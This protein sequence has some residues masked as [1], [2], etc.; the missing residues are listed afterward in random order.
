MKMKCFTIAILPVVILI[1]TILSFAVNT[2]IQAQCETSIIDI[3]PAPVQ[4][5]TI[6][7]IDFDHFES[8]TLLFTVRLGPSAGGDTVRLHI[9]LNINL[10]NGSTY[11]NAA[12]FTSK[13]FF[14]PQAG[15]TYTNLDIGRSIQRQDFT[16]D[17]RAKE[18]VQDVAL[19]TGKF[20]A[21]KYT[22]QIAI[23]CSDNI[24]L[25]GPSIDIVLLNSSR[26]DLLSP[27]EGETT[28]EF[29]LFEFFH[30]GNKAVLT[31][32]EINPDQSREDAISHEPPMVETELLGQNSF[33]YSGGRPLEF[34][35]TYAWKVVSKTAGPGGTEVEVSSPIRLFTVSSSP[36]IRSEDFILTYLKDTYGNRYPKI[37]QDIDKDNYI[38]TG[39]YLLNGSTY[40]KEDLLKLLNEL[41]STSDSIELS[42]E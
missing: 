1:L 22:F 24:P 2:E 13:G 18:D 32:A 31:V 41:R 14:V 15:A 23:I 7:D 27:R 19:A 33:L 37:F 9:V 26:V 17:S 12:D 36:Q 25:N 20:P 35:K 40:S 29:P 3:I 21:G 28:N 4:Q 42:F 8:A 38:L 11:P 10:A 30:D 6:A 16:L 39:T 5:L 34:G